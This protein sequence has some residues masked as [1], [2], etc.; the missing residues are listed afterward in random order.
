[1]VGHSEVFKILLQ[2]EIRMSIMASPH[3]W[4]NFVGMLVSYPHQLTFPSL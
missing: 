3:A 4:T 2:I 1:M